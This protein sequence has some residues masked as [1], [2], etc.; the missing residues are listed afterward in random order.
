MKVSA[1]SSICGAPWSTKTFDFTADQNRGFLVNTISELF[2][3]KTMLEFA[4]IYLLDPMI[5]GA[6][7]DGIKQSVSEEAYERIKDVVPVLTK[8]LP[9]GH[10]YFYDGLGIAP[11]MNSLQRI[12]DV[13]TD[14]AYF[15]TVTGV[16]V[17]FHYGDEDVGVTPAARSYIMDKIPNGKLFTY[18]GGH[19][20]VP[21]VA[22]IKKMLEP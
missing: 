10:E 5:S 19:I 20:E 6:G 22:A 21:L 11:T 16:N 15:N 1:V 4:A 18:H 17:N 13:N 3:N 2:K 8:D 12:N 14:Y 9:R 7:E